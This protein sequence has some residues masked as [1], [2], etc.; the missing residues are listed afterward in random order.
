MKKRF[1][2]DVNGEYVKYFR[3]KVRRDMEKERQEQQNQKNRQLECQQFILRQIEEKR[4]REKGMSMDEFELNKGLLKE[5]AT[6]RKDLKET[7]TEGYKNNSQTGVP[8]L[9]SYDIYNL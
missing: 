2:K 5:I 4:Q 8:T 9:A 1:Q 6:K 7:L 3:D